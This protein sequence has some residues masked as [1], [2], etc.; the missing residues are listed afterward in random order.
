MHLSHLEK[1]LGINRLKSLVLSQNF[2]QDTKPPPQILEFVIQMQTI[3]A[4]QTNPSVEVFW[5]RNRGCV[6][7]SEEI[8]LMVH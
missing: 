4:I 6:A 5:M 3:Q 7:T 2:L 1:I 8:E